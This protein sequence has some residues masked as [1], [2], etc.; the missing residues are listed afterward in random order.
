MT[1]IVPTRE[2][3][4]AIRAKMS[5]VQICRLQAQLHIKAG[6]DAERDAQAMFGA[7]AQKY[8]FDPAVS[9]RFDDATCELVADD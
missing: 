2:E 9:F 6:Q 8:G 1:R 5:E 7:L 3:Y 4:Y